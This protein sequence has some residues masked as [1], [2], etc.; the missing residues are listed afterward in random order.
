MRICAN[1]NHVIGSVS[2][3]G[4]SSSFTDSASSRS[5]IPGVSFPTGIAV[6]CN[7]NINCTDLTS[8]SRPSLGELSVS[9]IIGTQLGHN[10]ALI[11][12]SDKGL[13]DA[14][15]ALPC[16]GIP[17]G[18]ALRKRI[19]PSLENAAAVVAIK[20][21]SG[22]SRGTISASTTKMRLPH[23]NLFQEVWTVRLDNAIGKSRNINLLVLSNKM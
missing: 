1:I 14:R 16:G 8:Q 13:L 4:P 2:S 22:I 6:L 10:W 7:R 3:E 11:E 21:Y 20:G 18:I 5:I 17:K 15:S 9:S 23:S 19:V 12:L